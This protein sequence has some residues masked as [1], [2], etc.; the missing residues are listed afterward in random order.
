M[1][2]I[3]EYHLN[4]GVFGFVD[5][6][7]ISFAYATDEGEENNKYAKL[8]LYTY[9]GK[10]HVI[11]GYVGRHLQKKAIDMLKEILELKQQFEQKGVEYE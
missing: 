4:N 11:S 9:S 8:V 2:P 1:S 6:R 10:E 7:D 3:Y 5:V